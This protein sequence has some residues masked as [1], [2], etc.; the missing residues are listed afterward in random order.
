MERGATATIARLAS[1]TPAI[2]IIDFRKE[3]FKYIEGVLMAF[4]FEIIY[5]TGFLGRSCGS[6]VEPAA[7]R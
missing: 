7:D 6:P 2:A 5:L 4:A 1:E 3:L